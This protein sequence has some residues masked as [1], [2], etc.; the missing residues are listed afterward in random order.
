MKAS[1]KLAKVLKERRIGPTRFGEMLKAHGYSSGYQLGHHWQRG[2]GFDGNE[3]NQ[4]IAAAVL[5][6]Q[7]G[8]FADEDAAPAERPTPS[9]FPSLTAYLAAHPELSGDERAFLMAQPLSFDPDDG[10]IT[11]STLLAAYRSAKR[12]RPS[13][14]AR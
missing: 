2:R 7:P 9:R 14:S 8:Y 13:S 5:E 3:K 6:L 10:G 12:S 4:L 11:W 1:E